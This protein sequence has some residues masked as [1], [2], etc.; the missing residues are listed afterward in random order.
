MYF[1]PR[2]FIKIAPIAGSQ[3]F[4]VFKHVKSG[5]TNLV[6]IFGVSSASYKTQVS[7]G[8]KRMSRICC[9]EVKYVLYI[10]IC[11]CQ[12]LPFY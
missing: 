2:R 10:N 3:H 12:C 7:P 11:T 5:E 9:L 1:F 6:F 4:G 8:N